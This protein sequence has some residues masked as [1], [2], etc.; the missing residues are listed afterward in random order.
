MKMDAHTTTIIILDFKIKLER[1]VLFEVNKCSEVRTIVLT[2]LCIIIIII[3]SCHH[4]NNNRHHLRP[5]PRSGGAHC[6]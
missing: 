1:A 5:F 4:R 3:L 6:E 2:S